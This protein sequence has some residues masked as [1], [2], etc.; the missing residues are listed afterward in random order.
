M[1]V[2]DTGTSSSVV[3]VRDVL[4]GIARRWKSILGFTLLCAL[5]GWL[6]GL[7]ATPTYQS[8]AQVLI[9]D[10]ETPYSRTL[11]SDLRS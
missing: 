8:Q 3:D 7:V 9:E 1:S 11:R 2:M 4:R 10:L 5:A 6:F